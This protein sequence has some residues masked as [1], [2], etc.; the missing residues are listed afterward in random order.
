MLK[1][2]LPEVEDVMAFLESDMFGVEAYL[3]IGNE[4]EK[5][6]ES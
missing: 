1:G 3:I 5:K 4:V 6:E 2:K